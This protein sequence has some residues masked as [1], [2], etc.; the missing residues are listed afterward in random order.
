MYR[1]PGQ[2][3]DAGDKLILDQLHR[4]EGLLHHF[5]EAGPLLGQVQDRPRNVPQQ[6]NRPA[7]PATDLFDA[8]ANGPMTADLLSQPFSQNTPV[9]AELSRIDFPAATN[10]SLDHSAIA[11]RIESYFHRMHEIHALSNP[12]TWQAVYATASLSNFGRSIEGCTVLLLAALGSC[13][14]ER[15][16]LVTS[17]SEDAP[18]AAYFAKAWSMLPEILLSNS[19]AAIQCLVLGAIYLLEV[20]RPLDAWNVSNLAA[21][22]LDLHLSAFPD[23]FGPEV[24]QIKR[25]YWNLRLLRWNL[26]SVLDL[27]ST[28]DEA[29][30]AATA[31]GM[32]SSFPSNA[33][34]EA[35]GD[36]PSHLVAQIGLQ[37]LAERASRALPTTTSGSAN[38]DVLLPVAASFDDQL[39]QWYDRLPES[40]KFPQEGYP[41]SSAAQNILRHGFFACRAA[42][43]RPFVFAIVHNPDAADNDRI[44]LWCKKCLEA[45][46]RQIEYTS[47]L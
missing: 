47:A 21:S 7:Q 28:S 36:A 23:P 43:F 3:L 27:P 1:E 46:V 20:Y 22:K 13:A 11:S 19:I 26:V 44:T 41:S 34:L 12:S 29:P 14:S 6:R 42:M 24:E 37:Q 33:K 2:K 9:S 4:I 16:L 45:S 5:G 15:R 10:V 39:N 18:G 30:Q 25:I 8:V 38:M 31:V 40:M 17:S 35:E 32:P